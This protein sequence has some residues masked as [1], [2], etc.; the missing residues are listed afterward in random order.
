MISMLVSQ[1]VLYCKTKTYW[2]NKIKISYPELF[3]ALVLFIYLFLELY[4]IKTQ[5]SNLFG[6]RVLNDSLQPSMAV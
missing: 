5:N 1:T 4:Y 3:L 6:Q 2:S